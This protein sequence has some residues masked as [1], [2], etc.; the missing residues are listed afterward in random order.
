MWQE[1]RPFLLAHKKAV[2]I[3]GDSITFIGSLILSAEA[4]FK[5]TQII[6]TARKR[7]L[8]ARTPH[9]KSLSGQLVTDGQ[10]ENEWVNLWVLLAKIGILILTLGFLVLLLG[11]IFTE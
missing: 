8:I 5:K 1:I 2:G 11:R 7:K 6:S 3:L 10:V 9:L 4:L